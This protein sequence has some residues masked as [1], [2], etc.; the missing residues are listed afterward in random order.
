MPILGI[1]A[2]SKLISNSYESI[3]TVTVSTAVS[4]ISFS[5][6]PATYKHLQ[7]RMTTLQDQSVRNV[8]LQINSDTATNYAWHELYG[9]GSAA[10]S[11]AGTSQTFIKTGFTN[12]P[13]ASYTGAAVVNILDYANTNKYKTVRTLTGSDSNGGGFVLLRSGLWQNTNA[14][15]SLTFSAQLSNF[16][17]YTQF[18]L[19][20]I[21][22]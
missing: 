11:G 20:G 12:S 13:S 16:N 18:A 21:K 17:Q 15:T 19:Y 5:S 7:I 14:I 6:I 2:S 3:S 8:E 9:D 1:I 4:S 22:G 10:S